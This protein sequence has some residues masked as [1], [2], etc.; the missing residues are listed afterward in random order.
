MNTGALLCAL[1]CP[2][3]RIRNKRIRVPCVCYRS[4][5]SGAALHAVLARVLT[6]H[7]KRTSLIQQLVAAADGTDDR[8]AELEREL[9]AAVRERD[10]AVADLRREAQTTERA[11]RAGEVCSAPYLA[12]YPVLLCK[13]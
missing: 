11:K 12:P 13:H 7:E 1:L 3:V 2:S 10:A 5:P 9:K 8:S 4:A 6:E